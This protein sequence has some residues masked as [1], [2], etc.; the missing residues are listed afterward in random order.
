M[1]TIAVDAMGGDFGPR[2]TVPAV[3]S[4]LE[5]YSDLHIQLFGNRA[6][7]DPYLQNTFDNSRLT[8]I[9]T[10]EV[11][12]SGERTTTALRKRQSSMR[13]AIDLV[14]EEKAQ[15]MV[16][17]GNTGA[18]VAISRYVLKTMLGIDRPALIGRIPNELGFSYMLDLGAN[19]E[20]DSEN[21]HQFAIMGSAFCSALSQKKSPKVALLNIGSEEVKGNEEIRLTN[22]SLKESESVNYIGY[23]EGDDIYKGLAD[24]IVTNG[25]SGNIALKTSEGLVRYTSVVI[26]DAFK[27]N[28][29]SRIVGLLAVPILERLYRGF[30]PHL[31]NGGVLLGVQGVVVK[32]HGKALA[33]A[34]GV[35][36][37]NA[38]VLSKNNLLRQISD[39]LDQEII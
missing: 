27:H 2:V 14:R 13:M 18:L 6:K 24:V 3:L 4:S 31:K 34:F 26:R 25:F 36:I 28:L 33:G 12:T 21:L 38:Y 19:V 37:S 1:V 16:S 35:A 15:A 5:K 22:S 10:D 29:Y 23:I 8:I 11:V 39:R 9:H 20:C 32:S 17:A 7:L 30:E